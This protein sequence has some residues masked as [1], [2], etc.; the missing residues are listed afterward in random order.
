MKIFCTR[1]F[2]I[3]C[4][5]Y[6]VT[7][8]EAKRQDRGTDYPTP[9]SAEVKGVELYRYSLLRLSWP[10]LG[11]NLPLS[12]HGW[13]WRT[14]TGPHKKHAALASRL[15]GVRRLHLVP[16]AHFNFSSLIS[17]INQTWKLVPQ[18]VFHSRDSKLK[19]FWRTAFM[20]CCYFSWVRT[21]SV[22]LMTVCLCEKCPIFVTSSVVCLSM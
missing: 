4:G 1:L 3:L 6:R 7:F 17:C 22:S 21:L 13:K 20:S 12:L 11:W 2:N 9:S 19:V 14:V 8:P 5:V 10:G 15:R 18:A 16:Y